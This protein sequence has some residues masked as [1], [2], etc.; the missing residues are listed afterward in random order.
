MIH[1]DLLITFSED[2][3]NKAFTGLRSDIRDKDSQ[4]LIVDTFIK[5][6]ELLPNKYYG[7][8]E[9]HAFLQG[10]FETFRPWELA[11]ILLLQPNRII[12]RIRIGRAWYLHAPLVNN[13]LT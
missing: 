4:V 2:E 6:M 5:R 3:L 9:L 8:K 12:R 1:K 11:I 10:K 7:L 13:K